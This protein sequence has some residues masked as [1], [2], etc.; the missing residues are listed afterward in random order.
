MLLFHSLI[1]LVTFLSAAPS[2]SSLLTGEQMNSFLKTNGEVTLL[3]GRPFYFSGV[4]VY[5]LFYTQASDLPFYFQDFVDIKATMVRTWLF[6]DGKSC[7]DG[8]YVPYRFWF[9]EAENG[10]VIFN[11]D[12]ESGIGRFDRV[13]Q[14]AKQYGVKLTVSLT[15]N[16]KD[17]GGID[18]W[19]RKFSTNPSKFHSDFYWNEAVKAQF[20]RYVYHVLNRYNPLTGLKYKDDPTIAIIELGNEFRCNGY[21][22]PSDPGCNSQMVTA[23]IKEMSAYIKSFDSNH[24]ISIGDEGF[25]NDR[26]LSYGGAYSNVWDGSSGMDFYANA[27][28]PEID[29]LSF[30]A[31]FDQWN[32]PNDPQYIENTL[33]YIEDHHNVAKKVGK[34]LYAGEYAAGRPEMR[35]RNFPKIQKKIADLN[36]TGSLMWLWLSQNG[37]LPCVEI[38]DNVGLIYGVCKSNQEV[39]SIIINHGESMYKKFMGLK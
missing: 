31:Y 3:A 16:W 2:Q 17:F 6:C 18:W 7:S 9:T 11:D 34:P 26:G 38:P 30:H 5:R 35:N 15:N 27:L 10:Q 12:P 8:S 19:V 22:E 37:T 29:I 4:N 20:K 39:Q 1:N 14:A 23:W 21:P 32:T 13:I 25:F 28:L 36:L 33:K 24:L